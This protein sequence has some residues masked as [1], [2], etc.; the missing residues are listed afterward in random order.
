MKVLFSSG[1]CLLLFLCAQVPSQKE[2]R[3]LSPF[4]STRADVER[5]LGPPDHNAEN[6]LLTYYLPDATVSIWFSTNPQCKKQLPYESW[7]VP[8]GTVTAIRVGLKT[9]VPINETGIDL[10]RFKQVPGDY[11]LVGHFYYTNVEDD[12]S[13]EVGENFL[14][15]YIYGP[16]IKHRNLRCTP[17]NRHP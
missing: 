13:Y 2:W 8:V 4:K 9:P 12:F 15:A 7:D 16:G 10:T 5:L 1:F 14:S 3:G 6:E 17:V 11:D